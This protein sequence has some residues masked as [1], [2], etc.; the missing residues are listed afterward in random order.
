MYSKSLTQGDCSIVNNE[1]AEVELTKIPFTG[2]MMADIANA[3]FP[4]KSVNNEIA[5][6]KLSFIHT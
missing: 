1:I 6:V 5:E 3:K 2:L 4:E